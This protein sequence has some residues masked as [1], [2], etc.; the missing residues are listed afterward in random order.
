M[1]KIEFK[2]FVKKNPNL[3]KFV[4]NNE[5]TWQKFYEM[6]DMYG[7]NSE[8]WNEYKEYKQSTVKKEVVSAGVL[9]EFVN[10]FKTLNLD[11]VQDGLNS[12]G[13]VISVL[14]DFGTSNNS[15][16]ETT[17][18]PRPIYKHFED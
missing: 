5:M 18:K 13:R 9:S 11:E 12:V 10:W 7:E 14:Q 2:E 17:Y 1:G 6:Y 3:Y 8:V 16:T 4:K 15:S